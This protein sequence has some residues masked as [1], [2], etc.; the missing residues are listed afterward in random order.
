MLHIEEPEVEY[1]LRSSR[2]VVDPV[3]DQLVPQ[4][5]AS[6]IREL[7]GYYPVERLIF[8]LIKNLQKIGSSIQE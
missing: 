8:W 1:G 2:G 3:I 4:P 5:Y 7:K 6:R